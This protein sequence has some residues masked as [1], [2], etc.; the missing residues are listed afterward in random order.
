MS[1]DDKYAEWKTIQA[2]AG[3]ALLKVHKP[4]SAAIPSFDNRELDL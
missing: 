2:L 4:K 3:Q 1:K